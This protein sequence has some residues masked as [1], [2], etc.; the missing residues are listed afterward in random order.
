MTLIRIWILLLGAAACAEGAD[1]PIVQTSQDAGARPDAGSEEDAGPSFDA[2]PV[3]AEPLEGRSGPWGACGPAPLTE[4]VPAE[5]FEV[6]EKALRPGGFAAIDAP[7]FVNA[8]NC[9]ETS[10]GDPYRFG[11]VDLRMLQGSDPPDS[12]LLLYD[13]YRIAFFCDGSRVGVLDIQLRSG[14]QWEVSRYGQSSE[15]EYQVERWEIDHSPDCTR[16]HIVERANSMNWV[17][18]TDTTDGVLVR[19]LFSTGADTH[20]KAEFVEQLRK[21][22]RP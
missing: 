8:A 12:F 14:G 3:R 9:K 16:A 22:P 6:A 1:A 5:V 10:L 13:V 21:L 7:G 18:L 4:A 19:P 11:I 2:G 20:T 15:L 17:I